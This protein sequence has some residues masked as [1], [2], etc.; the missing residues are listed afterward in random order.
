LEKPKIITIKME[1]LDISTV[2]YGKELQKE[3]ET[4]KYYKYNKVKHL[5]KTT[6]QDRR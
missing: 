1:S 3:K 6:D 5:I 4:R 2:I